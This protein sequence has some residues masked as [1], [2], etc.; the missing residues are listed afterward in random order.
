MIALLLLALVGLAP[1]AAAQPR[2]FSPDTPALSDSAFQALAQRC[3]PTAPLPTL[4]SI[5][6]VESGFH[7]FALSL[8]YPETAGVRL[9]LGEGSVTLTRQPRNLDEALRWTRWFLTQGQTVSVGLMQLNIEHL[10]AFRTSLEHA[11]DACTNLR[12]GW[13]IFHDKYAQASAVM[14]RGQLALHAALSAYNSGTLLGGFRNGYVENV[15]AS[16]HWV[17]RTIDPSPVGLLAE[18]ARQPVPSPSMSADV[19]TPSTTA[20]PPE[21]VNIS[22]ADPAPGPPPPA[23]RS[24]T[25]VPWD[26]VRASTT[27]SPGAKR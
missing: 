26:V 15:M 12:L 13:T 16:P 17:T 23:V 27:W 2:M 19:G 11:F 20:T 5:V 8:N 24:P 22:P 9:G 10:A 18:P 4:R 21:A 6:S 3:A 1:P 25:A 7:P 14:G